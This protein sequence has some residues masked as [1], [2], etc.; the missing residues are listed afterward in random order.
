MYSRS[1]FTIE[2]QRSAGIDD[3]EAPL[4]NHCR[5]GGNWLIVGV[6]AEGRGSQPS[7]R[8]VEARLGNALVNE[9]SNELLRVSKGWR[10]T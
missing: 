9:A 7:A 10:P 5:V 1:L 4:G 3:G 6:D 8:V 2:P